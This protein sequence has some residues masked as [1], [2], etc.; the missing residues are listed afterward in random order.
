MFRYDQSTLSRVEVNSLDL[1]DIPFTDQFEHVHFCLGSV[2]KVNVGSQP[3]LSMA[4]KYSL[5][6]ILIN[7]QGM[8]Y[9]KLT[10]DEY[11]NYKAI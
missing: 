1:I 11:F 2:S 8:L 7:R 10:I 6:I 4:S 3:F 5:T 9:S